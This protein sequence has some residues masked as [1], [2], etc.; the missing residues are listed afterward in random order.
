MRTTTGWDETELEALLCNRCLAETDPHGGLG[1]H[2]TVS[3]EML[4]PT[5]LRYKYRYPPFQLCAIK[6]TSLLGSHDYT[7]RS[8]NRGVWQCNCTQI[9]CVGAPCDKGAT[10]LRVHVNLHRQD[11]PGQNVVC[12][13]EPAAAWSRQPDEVQPGTTEPFTQMRYTPLAESWR[14]IWHQ[15]LAGRHIGTY[16]GYSLA[17]G[18][19][20]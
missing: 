8:V 2:M 6:L 13:P 5:L 19:G 9:P 20:E 10:T 3:H 11:I 1:Q 15:A 14:N 18:G 12:E 7:T 16:R 4:R 17:A